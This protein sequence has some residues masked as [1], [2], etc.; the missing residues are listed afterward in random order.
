VLSFSGT[1][2]AGMRLLISTRF[3]PQPVFGAT[4]ILG[5][6]YPSIS[7]AV[8]QRCFTGSKSAGPVIRTPFLALSPPGKDSFPCQF[9]SLLPP[10]RTRNSNGG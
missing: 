4:P 6:I 5:E 10:C 9:S 3:A 2:G 8:K 7:K 1:S